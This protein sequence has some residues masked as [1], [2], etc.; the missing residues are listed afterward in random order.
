MNA[1][2]AAKVLE[3]LD[4]GIAVKILA[5]AF[6]A[7]QDIRTPVRIG[8]GVLA[9]TQL[10]NLA[11]VPWIAHAGL[12]LS[13][14]VGAWLNAA[15][16][17]LGLRRRGL[18]RPQPGWGIFLARVG[19]AL[20]AT[21]TVLWAFD[22]RFDWIALGSQPLVRAGIVLGIIAA[23]ALAYFVTLRLTGL[24]PRRMLKPAVGED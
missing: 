23:A 8:I 18:Y 21:G 16:L 15:W 5:P 14:S 7:R 3:T 1:K 9:V 4:N 12:A 13:I 22:Q 20:A 24:D 10:L 6:Y 11:F 2:Q 19:A 17:L